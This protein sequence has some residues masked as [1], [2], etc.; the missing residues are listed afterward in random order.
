MEYWTR[1]E[2]IA[3]GTGNLWG[4]GGLSYTVKVS[5]NAFTGVGGDDG[6]VEGIF[7]GLAHEGMAGTLKRND[8]VGAFGGSR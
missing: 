7:V 4:D 6:A 3:P 5:G 1:F 2:D 8:L